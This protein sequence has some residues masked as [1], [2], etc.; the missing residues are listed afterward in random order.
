MARMQRSDGAHTLSE[1]SHVGE[2]DVQVRICQEQG[3]R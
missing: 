1:L 3:Q 2:P